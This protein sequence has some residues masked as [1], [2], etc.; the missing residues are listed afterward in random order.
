MAELTQ[1][2]EVHPSLEKDRIWIYIDKSSWGQAKMDCWS[3]CLWGNR[4]RVGTVQRKKEKNVP[5]QTQRQPLCQCQRLT[6]GQLLPFWTLWSLLT[7]KYWGGLKS[8]LRTEN[9]VWEGPHVHT[10]SSLS[11]SWSRWSWT[12]SVSQVRSTKHNKKNKQ[13]KKTINNTYQYVM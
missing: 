5:T 13:K 10:I 1:L 12:A 11:L 7:S 3:S 2:T 6:S 9:I 8:L 4:G